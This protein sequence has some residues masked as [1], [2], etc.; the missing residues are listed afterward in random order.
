MELTLPLDEAVTLLRTAGL[1]PS[2][3]TDVRGEAAAV[4]AKVKVD[5]LPGVPRA[6]RTM[7]R[8]A[9]PADARIDD[10]GLVGRTWTLS[11]LVSH[12][13]I[14]LDVSSFVTDAVRGQLAKAPAGVASARTEAGRTV[15]GVDLD[16]LA[17][18]LPTLLPAAKGLRVRVDGAS[19]G[20]QLRLVATVA[21]SGH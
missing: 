11:V 1:L 10:G 5:D 16:R 7:A 21:P 19:L 14:P 8:F 9:P 4:T 2:A 3:V 17:A 18:L 13:M 20:A 12:P 15:I 6:V